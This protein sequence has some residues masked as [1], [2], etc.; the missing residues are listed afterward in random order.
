MGLLFYLLLI[1]NVDFFFFVPWFTNSHYL[2]G[3]TLWSNSK[4]WLVQYHENVSEWSYLSRQLHN[5]NPS[6]N[7]FFIEYIVYI[8]ELTFMLKI[9]PYIFQNIQN[10][11][12]LHQTLCRFVKVL[13][14]NKLYNYYDMLIKGF[15]SKFHISTIQRTSLVI[16]LVLET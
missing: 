5:E 12:Y 14:V 8:D 16:L 9:S 13:Q 15:N 10:I 4:Y 1:G 2:F 11:I 6:L 3:V 7:I